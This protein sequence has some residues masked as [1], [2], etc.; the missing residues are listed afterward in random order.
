MSEM[1]GIKP[2]PFC[3]GVGRLINIGGH[4]LAPYV[5]CE[6]CRAQSP[7]SGPSIEPFITYSEDEVI[8]AW[9]NRS[10]KLPELDE[11][12]IGQI[13]AENKWP[14]FALLSLFSFY[15]LYF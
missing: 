4:S 9:N 2:C 3:G 1:N 5:E 8:A 6:T 13:F 10:I 15:L 7:M 12:T 14:F 11:P